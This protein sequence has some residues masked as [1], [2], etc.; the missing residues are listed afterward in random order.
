MRQN[1]IFD[2][3]KMSKINKIPGFGEVRL[4][5]EACHVTNHPLGGSKGATVINSTEEEEK[6][7][8]YTEVETGF[9]KSSCRWRLFVNGFYALSNTQIKR[10]ISS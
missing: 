2:M 1:R 6:A 8:L 9:V 4:E 3:D 10:R 7:P 5:A